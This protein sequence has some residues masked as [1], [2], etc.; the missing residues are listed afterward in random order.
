MVMNSGGKPYRLEVGF[1]DRGTA[2]K[3]LVHANDGAT[4]DDFEGGRNW[5]F[6]LV[7]F[8]AFAGFTSPALLTL[9]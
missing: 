9:L 2:A 3:K 4:G 8:A 1:G 5:A 6:M 7:L